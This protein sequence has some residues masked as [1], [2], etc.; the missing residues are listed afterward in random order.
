METG[1]EQACCGAPTPRPGKHRISLRSAVGWGIIALSCALAYVAD[2]VSGFLW[3]VVAV[4]AWF[5]AYQTV[6]ARGCGFAG[7]GDVT[8]ERNGAFERL[9]ADARA[10]RKR[11]GVAFLLV[12]LLPTGLA[13]SGWT[14]L[15]ALAFLAGWFGV[16]FLVASF[17][18]YPGCPEVGAI[19]S[20]VLRRDIRTRCRPME[21]VDRLRR[22][23]A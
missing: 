15:W 21:R 11:V 8:D 14:L 4:V 9:P 20:L 22:G 5:G 7:A 12:A 16:S 10:T 6:R 19:P 3:P 17:T 2:T 1:S 23:A 18:G 13:L